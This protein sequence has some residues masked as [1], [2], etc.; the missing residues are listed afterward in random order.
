[1][2]HH[3]KRH[4]RQVKQTRSVENLAV[5]LSADSETPEL[6]P[7]AHTEAVVV[8]RDLLTTVLTMGLL[9]LALVVAA[10][11]NHKTGWTL[12]FGNKLYKL[13]HIR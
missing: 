9:I 11:L 10:I 2:A 8:K 7:V 4:H 13:L 5:K 6:S 12:E 1:M 3:K